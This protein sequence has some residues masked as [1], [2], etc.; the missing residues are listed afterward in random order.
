MARDNYCN[1][2]SLHLIHLSGYH[3]KLIQNISTFIFSLL[4][5]SINFTDI[6]AAI[7]LG[8]GVFI[9]VRYSMQRLNL[10]PSDINTVRTAPG[11]H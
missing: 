10:I 6:P 5:H 2:S 9:I 8:I 7:S 4:T 11:K 3:I 1:C